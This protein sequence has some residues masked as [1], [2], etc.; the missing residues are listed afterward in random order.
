MGELSERTPGKLHGYTTIRPDNQLEYELFQKPSDSGVN[1][2]FESSI[3]RHVKESV[4]ALQFR[5]ATTLSSNGRAE[6]RSKKKMCN[7]LHGNGFPLDDIKRVQVRSG[8]P[9]QHQLGQ[10]RT[11][12]KANV[13]LPF[14]SDGLDRKVRR[15]I[16]RS[17]IPFRV[18]YTQGKSLKQTLVRSALLPKSQKCE[19][20]QRFVEQQ[21]QRKK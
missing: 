13:Y 3:P 8:Q 2:N 4:A 16:R 21:N 7:L 17:K 1:L 9:R 10:K 19:V 15:L 11:Q 20:H 12:P 14:R 5:R 6:E 18:V